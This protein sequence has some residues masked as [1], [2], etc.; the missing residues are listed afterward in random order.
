MTAPSA[1]E[2]MP[3]EIV[4]SFHQLA[5]RQQREQVELQRKVVTAKAKML[6]K[7]ASEQQQLWMTSSPRQ[8][9]GPQSPCTPLPDQRGAMAIVP[10]Q[11]HT[12]TVTLTPLQSIPSTS[13][14]VQMQ[15][16]P[17]ARS[18]IVHGSQQ[19]QSSQKMRQGQ[20]NALDPIPSTP[21][22][23]SSKIATA[24]PKVKETRGQD[25]ITPAKETSKAGPSSRPSSKRKV[26]PEPE[27]VDLISDD[28][29]VIK[30]KPCAKAQQ[31]STVLVSGGSKKVETCPVKVEK[32]EG[33]PMSLAYRKR[34]IPP[35]RL[36]Q[37]SF[38]VLKQQQH[39][40]SSILREPS[41]IPRDS[42]L[43]LLQQE[44]DNGSFV[45]NVL[46]NERSKNW[47]PD[48]RMVFS[49]SD[50]AATP[51]H[52][53]VFGPANPTERSRSLLSFLPQNTPMASFSV[54][55][56]DSTLSSQATSATV[57]GDVLSI[58][59]Q[60]SEILAHFSG[61]SPSSKNISQ[62]PN[63]NGQAKSPFSKSRLDS[64]VG[65]QH[66]ARLSSAN[67]TV[68]TGIP[69]RKVTDVSSES[70]SDFQPS[71]PSTP[72]PTVQPNKS[73]EK[74]QTKGPL[75]NKKQKLSSKFGFRPI[76]AKNENVPAT[77]PAPAV[78]LASVVRRQPPKTPDRPVANLKSTPG[79]P[80][81]T[82]MSIPLAHNPIPSSLG[83]RGRGRAAARQAKDRISRLAQGDEEFRSEEEIR[84]ADALDDKLTKGLGKTGGRSP[85]MPGSIEKGIGGL[86]IAP[87][88]TSHTPMACDGAAETRGA[89]E[90]SVYT[91]A[92]WTQD[93]MNGDRY[94]AKSI[95]SAEKVA[96]FP[97]ESVAD[98][99]RFFVNGGKIFRKDDVEK[100]DLTG[101]DWEMTGM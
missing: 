10:Q 69:K 41:T 95:A 89:R 65:T 54:Q 33:N 16:P 80:R 46:K 21:A 15:T 42:S 79:A 7:H 38:D 76:A 40:R 30:P 14:Q 35:D 37:I 97:A 59:S 98:T 70:G 36:R 5:M 52:V 47:T 49:Q 31:T 86:S 1:L 6:E 66:S 85:N 20:Q 60:G 24:T 99:E 44:K 26:K 19:S 17:P 94:V 45:D 67:P 90:G 63:L 32:N 50:D 55:E 61:S 75:P 23:K 3:P 88:L 58:K 39:G 34:G 73:R 18:T 48:L 87:A 81:R 93:R 72:C 91:S 53:H 92:K 56:S 27:I 83:A 96:E 62:A 77:P 71:P 82:R 2:R 4:A 12:E 101:G 57:K 11:Q 8:R 13:L 29:P 78:T 25:P 9:L 43:R 68:S 51:E 22:K 28:E 84:E 64:G 74:A 100:M